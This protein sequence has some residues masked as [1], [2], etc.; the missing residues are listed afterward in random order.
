MTR[1][2]P[3]P[4]SKLYESKKLYASK[5]LSTELRLIERL[6]RKADMSQAVGSTAMQCVAGARS[7]NSPGQLAGSSR[8][9]SIAPGFVAEK[10]ASFEALVTQVLVPNLPVHRDLIRLGIVVIMNAQRSPTWNSCRGAI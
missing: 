6:D 7:S 2:V 1:L 8:D 3:T 4:L 9:S 5:M 10:V